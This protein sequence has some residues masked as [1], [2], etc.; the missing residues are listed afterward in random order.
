MFHPQSES[1]FFSDLKDESNDSNDFKNACKFITR[2]VELEE[3]GKLEIERNYSKKHFRVA[4][5]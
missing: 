3:K 1:F 5:A 4:G 2:C